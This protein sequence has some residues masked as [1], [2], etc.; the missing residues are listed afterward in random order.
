[1]I[2]SREP[3]NLLS[4]STFEEKNQEMMMSFSTCCRL[5]QLRKKLRNDN[6]P[7]GLLS[8]VTLENKKQKD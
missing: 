2:T 4:F 6:K 5:L 7:L 8:F 3:P 1:M